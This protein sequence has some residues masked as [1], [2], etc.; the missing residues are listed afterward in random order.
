MSDCRLGAKR[1]L[2]P[3]ADEKT[4]AG[5]TSGVIA[6]TVVVLTVSLTGTALAQDG[7]P[8]GRPP[9]RERA[10]KGD[11]EAQFLLGR[12][13]EA[14]RSGLKKD[15]AE[16]A[17][18][19]RLSAE[20]GDPW[21]QASLGLLYRFGKGVEKDLVEAYAWLT[22]ATRATTGP[23]SESIAELRDAAGMRMTREQIDEAIKKADAWRV[24]PKP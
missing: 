4:Q 17:R 9:L 21:A 13:Y 1:C 8:P 5:D 12:N 19:Y 23:D 16:A 2:L 24:K 14:G 15:P 20:Q 18:W 10:A 7:P 11:A 3:R 6:I 22:L